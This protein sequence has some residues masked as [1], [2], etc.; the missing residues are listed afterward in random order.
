MGG[1]KKIQIGTQ[2]RGR[3]EKDTDRTQRRGK[4]EKDTDRDTK[5][6]GD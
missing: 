4:T 2:R 3:T 1:L 6:W 5:T